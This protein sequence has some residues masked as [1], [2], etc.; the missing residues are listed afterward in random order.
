MADNSNG[1]HKHCWHY[2]NSDMTT[3]TFFCCW[4]PTY[5]SFHLK[6][7]G[8]AL[9]HGHTVPQILQQMAEKHSVGLY[10]TVEQGKQ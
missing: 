10:H 6:S 7:S 2:D 4:C 8:H 5:F 3:I 9:L 1:T